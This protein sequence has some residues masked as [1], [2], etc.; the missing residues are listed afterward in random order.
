M[1]IFQELKGL[2]LGDGDGPRFSYSQDSSGLIF[3]IEAS[4]YS[5][6][7]EG[8][9]SGWALHQHVYLKM[10]EEQGEA[11]RIP[12]GFIVETEAVCRLEPVALEILDLP[13]RFPGS[14]LLKTAGL[15]ASESFNTELLPV[16]EDGTQQ[17]FYEING[18][19]LRFTS[20]E[21]YLLTGPQLVAF[22]A[23]ESHQSVSIGSRREDQNLQLIA[24]LQY[25]KEE[26]LRINLAQF[27]DLGIQMPESIGVTAL[28][29]ENGSLILV[30]SFGTDD[31][32]VEV[33]NRLDQLRGQNS[34]SA[35][36]RVGNN[37]ILLDEERLKAVH[38][39]IA[40]RH[41]EKEQ[42]ERFLQSPSAYL[43]AS[44]VNLDL[45]FSLRVHGAVEFRHGYFGDTDESGISWFE[46][47]DDVIHAP[48]QLL[49]KLETETDIAQFEEQFINA[50]K[51]GA[52]QL[53][54]D[55]DIFDISE[56]DHVLGEIE[57]AK[58]NLEEGDEQ[59]KPEV[60]GDI[61]DFDPAKDQINV[62]IDIALNDE[63]LDFKLNTD[64][65]SASYTGELDYTQYLR[66]PFSY[67]DDG[68]RWILGM[69]ESTINIENQDAG[70]HG[71]LLA[72]DM[73]LGK[74]FMS[75][76][77]IREYMRL[78]EERGDT[79]RPVLVVAPL[80]L[81]ENWV[82]EVNET[83]GQGKSPFDSI[84]TLQSSADLPK[85]RLNGGTETRQAADVTAETAEIKYC[86][87]I[88]AGPD[89]LDMPKRL[90]LTTYETLRDYQFSLASIDWSIVVFDEAQL[91]KSPNAQKTRAAKGLK[92]RFKLLAT[93]TPVEN[94]LAD[95]WCLMDTA[96]PGHLHSYQDFN[97]TYIKPITRAS[98]EE[99]S[100]VRNK[101]GKQL[102]EDVGSAMLRRVKEDQLGGL[103]SKLI[104]TGDESAEDP[105]IY[106]EILACEMPEGQRN[107]YETVIE[108]V[109][110]G[111]SSSNAGN[112]L[113]GLWRLQDVTLHP[114]LLE[115]GLIPI[116][117]SKKE[118]LDII[119]QSG[120][121]HC[122]F[123]LL[124][125]IE[126]R[127]EKVIIF[128]ISKNL[129]S[130]L[131]IA[132]QQVYGIGVHIINGDV[133]AVASS[134]EN[135]SRKGYIRDFEEKPGFGVIVMS[136]VAA[137]IGLTVVGANNV[138]H[139][140]RHWNPAKEAQATDRVY[141]IG[142]QQEVNVYL[143]ILKHPSIDSFDVNLNR[144]IN[145]KTALKNAV[146]TPEEVD[147][148][149]LGRR[150][151]GGEVTF[152]PT[153]DLIDPDT[154]KDMHWERFE[155][156]AAELIAAS[157]DGY[158]QLTASGTDSGADALVF[159]EPENIIL[160]VKH[161][162]GSV[163]DKDAARE[164]FSAKPMYEEKTGKSFTRMIAITNAN[165]FSRR[166]ENRAQTFNVELYALPKIKK[167][168][169]KYPIEVKKVM[170]RL[171]KGRFKI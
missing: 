25:A 48:S 60:S 154:L 64:I 47:R 136:P 123:R 129:Q 114:A 82:D 61:D 153:A 37:I 31:R 171:D 112:V 2:L 63:E 141:R 127:C 9:A 104:F 45:G 145:Q 86:L 22:L 165:K 28:E 125:E 103:P 80:G 170:E 58:K 53:T 41:I 161:T 73:G 77:A 163:M 75:L 13:G 105:V 14:F 20:E 78:A 19:F 97:R 100:E 83:Y 44:L 132:L 36:L 39:V 92:S 98:P 99:R 3:H 124:N 101:I 33:N 158:A 50:V 119:A 57:K 17:P 87:K 143:P 159:A 52:D 59:D 84:V 42:V 118:A 66:T 116:P 11:E 157:V 106:E 134:S 120:K 126:K 162:R 23:L 146:V 38:E 85:Y 155:A 26:G 79:A 68:I 43:D 81:L 144:L 140:Q 72:D 109:H 107:K 10:L 67:Q 113:A 76:V 5:K 51:T 164:V 167:L 95:F 29:Q 1:S 138:I 62:V 90:V 71:A 147:P 7:E 40:S 131:A 54:F 168:L 55:G 34:T 69:A 89:R 56:R 148:S 110:D 6:I 94:S 169:K 74:T 15:A 4:I 150:L 46:G 130:F 121:L 160:Q 166:I 24:A 102:R 135:L 152:D 21:V 122:V 16:L 137:G 91:I 27:E 128:A 49:R 133:K 142:Q 88:G 96:I 139:L 156:F 117:S 18:P 12:N 30:P 65:A 93:G 8:N 108:L 35:T 111:E 70:K 32:P 115:H 149:A 151:F